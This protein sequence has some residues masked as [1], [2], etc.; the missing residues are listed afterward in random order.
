MTKHKDIRSQRRVRLEGKQMSQIV[1]QTY[2]SRNGKTILIRSALPSDAQAFLNLVHSVLEESEFMMRAPEEYAMTVEPKREWISN[3]RK[4]VRNTIIVAEINGVLIGFLNFYQDT[5]RRLTHQGELGMGVNKEWRDQG[6]GK[7]L[8]TALLTW[9]EAET[10]LE[11][12][13]L[14][15]FATNERAIH[16]YTS[17]GFRE[18]GRLMK[19]VKTDDGSYIDLLLMSLFLKQG[20]CSFSHQCE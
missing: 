3:Q 2:C 6:I 17:L 16:L 9:A 19:Q 4:R 20:K 7:A 10:L 8:L 15:V 12:L 18:E 13:R 1:S 14:E 5:R 11:K